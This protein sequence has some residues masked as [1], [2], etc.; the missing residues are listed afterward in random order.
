MGR[1]AKEF[2]RPDQPV[3]GGGKV[4]WGRDR[5]Q[6]IYDEVGNQSQQVPGGIGD[7][8]GGYTPGPWGLL[9]MEADQNTANEQFRNRARTART[10]ITANNTQTQVQSDAQAQ[11]N[12]S[13]GGGA[14]TSPGGF[15][16]LRTNYGSAMGGIT[17]KRGVVKIEDLPE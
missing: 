1:S 7:T 10:N 16:S 6:D 9:E 17:P 2:C 5:Y 3:D 11:I 13:V 15:P 14:S 8:F 12:R 4:R